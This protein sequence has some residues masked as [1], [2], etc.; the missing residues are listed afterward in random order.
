MNHLNIKNIVVLV[1][2]LFSSMLNMSSSGVEVFAQQVMGSVEEQ[3]PSAGA[4]E[5]RLSPNQKSWLKSTTEQR[6]RIAERIGEDGARHFA[7]EKEWKPVLDGTRKK[8]PHGPD[9]IYQSDD[10]IVHV[11]E[12]KGGSGRLGKGYGYQQGSSEWAVKASERLLRS[13][14]ASPSEKAAAEVVLR[15][16]VDRKVQVH[17]VETKHVLGEPVAAVLKATTTPTHKASQLAKQIMQEQAEL[18]P[19]FSKKSISPVTVHKGWLKG[20]KVL[21]FFGRAAVPVAACVD[22]GSRLSESI[23]TEAE[24]SDGKIS[25][26]DRLVQHSSNAAGLVGGWSG[27]ILGA[28]AGAAGGGII[29]TAAAPGPGTAVGVAL[30]S[31][32]GAI[33]GYFTGEVAGEAGAPI[34]VRQL[35]S[36]SE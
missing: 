22:V 18:T 10:G 26:E 31:A 24:F 27:A 13:A 35:T 11:I 5:G 28:K 7:R 12:A 33:A 2:C 16:A 21:K 29:G 15:A 1:N 8:C 3:V 19:L 32:S 9:Q 4:R 6:V 20:S 34:L 14:N 36:P 25:A 23:A 17:V 30:G